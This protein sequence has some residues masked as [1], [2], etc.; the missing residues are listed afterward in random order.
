MERP[1][2]RPG[3][4]FEE[5]VESST[6]ESWIRIAGLMADLVEIGIGFVSDSLPIA[7]DIYSGKRRRLDRIA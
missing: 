3:R 2:G 7:I 1:F 5:M 4:A 6:G